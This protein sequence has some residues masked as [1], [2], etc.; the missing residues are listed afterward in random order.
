MYSLELFRQITMKLQKYFPKFIWA[1]FASII[2]SLVVSIIFSVKGITFSVL[3]FFCTSISLAFI[4]FEWHQEKRETGQ[5]R[6]DREEDIRSLVNEL[7]KKIGGGLHLNNSLIKEKIIDSLTNTIE[8]LKN[9]DDGQFE[10]R[11]ES[12]TRTFK[13]LCGNAKKTVHV[14]CNLDFA[15]D[16]FFN[17]QGNYGEEV[18]KKHIESRRKNPDIEIIR[19]FLKKSEDFNSKYMK[20][21]KKYEEEGIQNRFLKEEYFPQGQ[22]ISRDFTIID[23]E[24]IG[25]LIGKTKHYLSQ[26]SIIRKKD[27]RSGNLLKK[28][29]S[30][31]ERAFNKS[32]SFEEQV[33]INKAYFDDIA[34]S[35]SIDEK[36]NSK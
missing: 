24:Q 30:C 1:I 22:G 33:Q 36:H 29:E 15:E 9:I 11:G 4:S 18:L 21:L 5:L 19:I 13:D 20:I 10:L 23:K 25:I 12:T 27:V 32:I 31:F 8:D 7:T 35:S 14:I 34:N 26:W 16:N 3:L 28:Y 2:G 6:I 17:L